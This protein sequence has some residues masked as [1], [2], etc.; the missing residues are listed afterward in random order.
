MREEKKQK[1]KP[2][3]SSN[4]FVLSFV[5]RGNTFHLLPF[6]YYV[7]CNG[8]KLERGRARAENSAALVLKE[9]FEGSVR[10]I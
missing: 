1:Q 10:R 2:E 5:S 7:T 4:L 9:P 3:N 6:W 8:W